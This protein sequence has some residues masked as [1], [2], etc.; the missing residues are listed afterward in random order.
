MKGSEGGFGCTLNTTVERR[1]EQKGQI[2][3]MIQ[4]DEERDIKMEIVGER[5]RI[6]AGRI[7]IYNIYF[8]GVQKENKEKIETEALYEE[9]IKK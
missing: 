1:N 9:I 5:L 2:R 7:K 4:N 3:K 6:V 8:I